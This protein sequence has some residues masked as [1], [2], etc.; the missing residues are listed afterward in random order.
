MTATT[1][2][3]LYQTGES[4]I[5][6][7]QLASWE[8]MGMRIVV[9]SKERCFD[10]GVLFQEKNL[11]T[12]KQHHRSA[13]RV[14]LDITGIKGGRRKIYTDQYGNILHRFSVFSLKDKISREITRGVFNINNYL[15]RHKERFRFEVYTI[16]YLE[17]QKR[18]MGL[19]PGHE[20]WLSRSGYEDIKKAQKYFQ[21]FS[22]MDIQEVRK[23]QISDWL[24]SLKCSRNQKRK[25]IGHLGHI[26]RWA[27]RR[28]E[29]KTI[30][31][32]P[33]ITSLSK[34]KAG[35]TQD[36]QS[37][38]LSKIPEGMDKWI[39]I[40]AMESGRRINEYR[41]TRVEDVIFSKSSYI[42]SGAFDCETWKPFPKV[43]HHAGREFPL[44]PMMAEVAR[45]A[46]NE[47]GP[48][49]PKDYLFA[50]HNRKKK[51][52]PYTDAVL[53]K[54]FV[55]A[56]KAAGYSCT[57]NEFGRHSMG[58]QLREAGATYSDI[59]DIL[60]NGETVARSNYTSMDV[61]KKSK[62]VNLRSQG[63][64]RDRF[65]EG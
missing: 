46:I 21:F 4:D 15:P 30:P 56:A 54:I 10:C 40:W 20:D 5:I 55:R 57:L 6:A 64:P 51:Y 49:G 23:P 37:E 58:K 28:E 35:L 65:G 63:Q 41:A 45:K 53:R 59:A 13:E 62:I 48:V 31:D 39:L 19:E 16:K 32:L 18:R 17:D 3:N 50:H 8:A 47:R 38:I 29:L 9:R 52:V 44:T 2:A 12:C 22:E 14:F 27:H 24:S 11:F 42:L 43:E 36:Q 60:D 7:F 25:L 34:K 26:L 1:L 33:R 61:I